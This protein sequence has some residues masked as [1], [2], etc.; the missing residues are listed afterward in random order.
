MR[1]EIHIGVKCA[2]F[3]SHTQGSVLREAEVAESIFHLRS[4]PNLWSH[5][6]QKARG[7]QKDE[8]NLVQLASVRQEGEDIQMGP[9]SLKKKNIP[10]GMLG[11]CRCPC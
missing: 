4:L 6:G 3:R 1:S 7:L 2:S 10:T 9:R 8:P 11:P 5:L